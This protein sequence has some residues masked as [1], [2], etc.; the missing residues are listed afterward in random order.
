MLRDSPPACQSFLADLC[1]AQILGVHRNFHEIKSCK[2]LTERRAGLVFLNMLFSS[3]LS[4]LRLT[5]YQTSC[6]NKCCIDTSG[7]APGGEPADELLPD[8]LR[9]R[10]QEGRPL[11]HRPRPRQRQLAPASPNGS[12][13]GKSDVEDGNP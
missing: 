11:R 12:L 9:Q 7:A 1:S 3:N 4:L 13:S 6:S 2:M 8:R 10:P 5:V